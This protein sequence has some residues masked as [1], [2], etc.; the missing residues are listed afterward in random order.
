M[1][2]TSVGQDKLNELAG[3]IFTLPDSLNIHPLVQ[4]A[5]DARL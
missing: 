4:K 2:D 3:K 1:Y 5:Y